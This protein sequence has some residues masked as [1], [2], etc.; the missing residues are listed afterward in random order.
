MPTSPA[1]QDLV[2]YDHLVL[3]YT[4][5]K[6]EFPEAGDVNIIEAIKANG[7][8]L[9]VDAQKAV[10]IVLEEGT[11]NG[12]LRFNGANILVH[13][14]GTAAYADVEDI[15]G[16]IEGVQVN[17]TDLVP[18]ANNK[19]NV[20][21]P[22]TVAQLTDA[23]DYVQDSELGTAAAKDYE[24]TL[25]NGANLPTGAAVQNYV[26][27][28]GY[29]TSTEVQTAIST[30][31]A[32]LTLLKDEIV[33]VLPSPS[34]ADP[35]TLYY[36]M[37]SATGYYDIY[38]LIS[39]TMVRLDDVSIDLSGYVQKTDITIVTNAQINAMFE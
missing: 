33:N 6:N 15:S 17:G 19:V 21:V 3:F 5:L 29:Q 2:D 34:D 26:A 24:A 8:P 32:G 9:T 31:I 35:N 10:D 27:G 37:N 22:T 36:L 18:D 39:G 11:A 7:V 30:A 13:G 14:L 16:T 12:T 38:K 28:L 1:Y 20:I 23:S 25:T 4:L